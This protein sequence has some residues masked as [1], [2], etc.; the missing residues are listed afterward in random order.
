VR[1]PKVCTGGLRA[2]V[3]ARLTPFSPPL[4][5]RPARVHCKLPRAIRGSPPHVRR[6]EIG[7]VLVVLFARVDLNGIHIRACSR[8]QRDLT[9]EEPEQAVAVEEPEIEVRLSLQ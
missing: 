3:K 9:I 4:S 6:E 8:V 5:S 1:W 7:T 2:A